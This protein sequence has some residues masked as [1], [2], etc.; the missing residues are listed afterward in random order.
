MN[1]EGQSAQDTP[2]ENTVSEPSLEVPESKPKVEETEPKIVPE[3]ASEAIAERVEAA[4]ETETA[5]MGGSEPLAEPAHGG[6]EAIA[7]ASEEQTSTPAKEERQPRKRE[8]E[9]AKSEVSQKEK[10]GLLRQM[11]RATIQLRREKKLV[12]IM[13]LFAKQTAVTNDEVEKLL[14]VSDATATR[15]LSELEKRGK[16]KQVGTIGRGVSYTKR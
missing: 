1:E 13:A 9:P 10:L 15:Y 8:E 16:L 6:A 12:K 3:T 7:E 4:P 14:H 2:P 5:Q 11:A